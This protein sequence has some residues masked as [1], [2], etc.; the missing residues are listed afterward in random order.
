MSDERVVEMIRCFEPCPFCADETPELFID[1]NFLAPEY[2]VFCPNCGARGS[3]S[4][5][6]VWAMQLWNKAGM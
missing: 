5:K 6:A 4:D 3:A 2:Y 1:G